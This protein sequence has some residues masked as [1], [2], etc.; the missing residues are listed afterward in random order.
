VARIAR[1]R[2]NN[3]KALFFLFLTD[4]ANVYLGISCAVAAAVAVG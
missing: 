2:V 4:D 3:L 1:E